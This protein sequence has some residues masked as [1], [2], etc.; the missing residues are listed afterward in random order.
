MVFAIQISCFFG[1]NVVSGDQ[2]DEI[3]VPGFFMFGVVDSMCCF[4]GIAVC[5]YPPK[6]YLEICTRDAISSSFGTLHEQG[7]LHG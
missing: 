5:Q 6:T 3:V 2:T 4:H 1:L 7:H